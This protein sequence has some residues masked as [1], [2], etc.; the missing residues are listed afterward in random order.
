MLDGVDPKTGQKLSDSS[1]TDNL[2]TFLIAGHETT[3]GLLSFAFYQLLKHPE[4]Y[5]KAQQEVDQV[6]GTG[7]LRAEHLSKLPYLNGVSVSRLSCLVASRPLT[8]SPQVLRETLRLSATIPIF[9]LASLKD[10]VIGGKYWIRKGQPIGVLLAKSHLDPAVFGEDVN[11]FHPE[12]MTD[13]NFE[14]LQK[15]FPN[16]WKPFGNGMR[17]CIGRAFAW[18]EALLTMAMLLQNFNFRMEDPN[19]QL[20]IKETLTLKPKDFYMRA[21]LRDGITATSLERRLAGTGPENGAKPGQGPPVVAARKAELPVGKPMSIYYGSNSGTCESLAQRLASDAASH[22]FSATVVDPLDGAN[23][24]LPKD[25]PVVIVT[26]SYEG[27]PPDN[28]AHFVSWLKS[29]KEK[30]LDGVSYAVFGCGKRTW[31]ACAVFARLTPG[32]GTTTGRRRSTGSPSSLTRGS[33]RWGEPDWPPWGSPTP[34]R[35]TCSPTLRRGKTRS[36]GR[37]WRTS[38]TLPKRP[39]ARP[40]SPA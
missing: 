21:T 34:P 27:E 10:Q 4:A 33:K 40:S 38:T 29:L 32:Q 1:I 20:A 23:Q 5:R 14:R 37:R 9:A 6:V 17:G 26:A 7:P 30:E 16:C 39:T 22:G 35:A 28:A 31:A 2:I 18:Q 15:E 24:K 36:S 13:E 25:Q 11:E 12:R 19:Y 8:A 3:S